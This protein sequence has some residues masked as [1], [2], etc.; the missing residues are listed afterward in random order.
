VGVCGGWGGGGG[1]GEYGRLPSLCTAGRKPSSNKGGTPLSQ[2][3]PCTLPTNLPTY[4]F[5][6][7]PEP[8]VD[9]FQALPS[10]KGERKKVGLGSQMRK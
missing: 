8:Q 4:I 5:P 2:W 9:V 6:S 3:V 10:A 7:S 1:G